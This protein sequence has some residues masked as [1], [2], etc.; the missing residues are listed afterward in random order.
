MISNFSKCRRG[1]NFLTDRH[2][3][4]TSARNKLRNNSRGYQ[5][6]SGEENLS[7]PDFFP[8]S[9]FLSLFSF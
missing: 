4:E 1:R 3:L 8:P 9:F 5:M 2:T 7:H 6:S